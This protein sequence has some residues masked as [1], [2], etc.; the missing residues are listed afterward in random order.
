MRQAFKYI[1]GIAMSRL[2]VILVLSM[3]CIST[4][5]L[6]ALPKLEIFAK[7][8]SY[9][10]MKISPTG[11]YIAFTYAE[12]DQVK[13]GIMDRSTMKPMSSFE[14]G[15]SRQV[16]S[17]RWLNNERVG[18][19]VQKITG[20]LDGTDP[21]TK[22]AAGNADGS[23]RRILWDFEHSISSVSILSILENEPD[24]V[25]LQEM[26]W[27]DGRAVKP[28][29]VNI[30]TGKRHRVDAGPIEARHTKPGIVGLGVDS[31]DEIRFAFEYDQGEDIIDDGDDAGYIHYKTSDGIWH[32]LGY[33]NKRDSSASM[34]ILGYSEDNNSFYF[35]S[36]HDQASSDTRGLFEFDMV[37]RTIKLLHRHPDVDIGGGVYGNKGQL[38]GAY[39]EPGYPE[40][41]Y[42]IS[43]ENNSAIAM[44]Q[45]LSAA[46]KN[47][48]VSLRNS[49]SDGDLHVVRVTSDRNPGKFFLFDSKKNSLT[50][51]A[52]SKPEVKAEEMARVEPFAVEARDGLKMY[53]QL[54]IP[55]NVKETNLPMVVYPHGGPYG[56]ADDWRWDRRA[57]MFAS[58]GYLVLQLNFRG[59]G[60]YGEDFYDAGSKE[61]GRK[62]QDDIT[63]ATKWAIKSGLADPERICIHGVSYGGYAAMH[64]VVKEPDLYKCSI[65]DAGVYEMKIQWD[66][67][68]SF[69][70]WK[71]NERKK[72]Y[73]NWA[74]GGYDYV[75][76]RSPVYHVDK[77]KAALLIVHGGSDVR[78]PMIN[79][80]VLEQHLKKAGKSYET[81]YK[82]EEGHGF[83]VEEN[84]IELY[85]TML[86]FLEKHI[87][88]GAQPLSK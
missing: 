8:P 39:L 54:T 59:S 48:Q 74:I 1:N 21:K 25:L 51:Y 12:G 9:R 68:D 3:V 30:N 11:K 49:T 53:G 65:P 2:V 18:M 57:Q 67:A 45:S 14:F 81:L 87:G 60:G 44:R 34:G 79:A 31:N 6:A 62:M 84:R 41:H 40:Y 13:L 70:G 17:F 19:M 23:N 10:D 75:K 29:R 46:F 43:D 72:N 37:T 78:V 63:D 85:Q 32:K 7:H 71:G 77:L 58:R 56:A 15:E 83:Q 20:W 47:E 24:Y 42:L 50:R 28:I 80:E 55:N 5:A 36:N 88:P 61:W 26:D 66:E 69:K 22:W 86:S 16:V 64:A 76:E 27:R 35:T 4:N 73:M 82:E 33:R 52:D 38:I